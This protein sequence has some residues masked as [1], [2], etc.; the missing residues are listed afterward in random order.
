MSQSK[1]VSKELYYLGVAEAVSKR[2]TCLNKQ[3]GAVIVKDDE[4]ISTGYNGAPRGLPNCCDIGECYRVKNNIQRG[5]R[6][7]TCLAAGTHVM[8]SNGRKVTIANLERHQEKYRYVVYSKNPTTGVINQVPMFAF[9]NG[10]AMDFIEVVLETG[11]RFKCTPDH[12]FMMED[13]SFK[14]AYE[15]QKLDKLAG[16]I[17]QYDPYK[18][19]CEWVREHVV[20]VSDIQHIH[21]KDRSEPVYDLRVEEHENFALD[22]GVNG[23]HIGIFVHNCSSLH[24]EQNAIISASRSDMRHG[25]MYIYGYDVTN[26]MLVE[27]PN[28]CILCKRMI[29]NAGIDEVIFADVDGIGRLSHPEKKYGFRLVKVSDWIKDGIMDLNGTYKPDKP[30]Y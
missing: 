26:D 2:S 8:I 12:K 23:A 21:L 9:M 16:M 22:V 10:E 5:T 14:C 11:Y 15:L 25:T 6:Y 29:I 17:W 4:I 18:P 24:A 27:N 30:G 28:S 1:R 13:G 7:E 19:N 3:W 20:T